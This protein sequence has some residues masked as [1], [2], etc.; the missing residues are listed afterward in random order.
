[1]TYC[2]A[3]VE[4]IPRDVQNPPAIVVC[5]SKTAINSACVLDCCPLVD[6]RYHDGGM[7]STV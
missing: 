4:G 6:S 2:P 1:M 3:P 7:G 5:S